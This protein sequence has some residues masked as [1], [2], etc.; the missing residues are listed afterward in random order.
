[1]TKRKGHQIV[2][3]ELVF[4]TEGQ[5]YARVLKM[6]GDCRVEAYCFDGANRICTIRGKM[7]KKVW[8]RPDDIILVGLRDYQDDKA[9]IIA[10]YTEDEARKLKANGEIPDSVKFGNEEDDEEEE[11]F[12]EFVDEDKDIDLEEL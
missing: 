2:K 8:I 4:K 12:F 6:L 5:E 3:R 11:T 7:R 1:M 9:D 10:K